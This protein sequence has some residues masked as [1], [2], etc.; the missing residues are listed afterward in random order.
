M[1]KATLFIT[2]ISC[3]AIFCFVG[4]KK[5]TEDSTPLSVT[6]IKGEVKAELNLTTSGKENVPEGTKITFLID[7]NDLLNSPDTSKK[8]DSYRYTAIVTGG[9][10]EIHVPARNNGTPVKIVPD[11]FEYDFVID[12]STSTRIVYSAPTATLN[13][14][15]G[16]TTIY[17]VYY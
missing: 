11:D 7:P 4:C 13:I 8:Y 1:K 9:R 6:T 16:T 15:A 17:D 2:A 5:K 14:Y 12:N 10:Y 3:A